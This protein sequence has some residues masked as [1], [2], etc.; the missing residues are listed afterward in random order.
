MKNSFEK[1][2]IESC[3]IE[4]DEDSKTTVYHVNSPHAFTQAAGYLKYTR[5]KTNEFIFFRGQRRLYG[6][7][8]PT[9]YRKI[10]TNRGISNSHREINTFSERLRKTHNIFASLDKYSIEA[11]LQHYGLNTTWIDLVDNI[12]V[13]LWFACHRAFSRG[14]GRFLHF[15]RR[16]P[17]VDSNPFAYILLIATQSTPMSESIPGYYKGNTTELID[18]RIST[19]SLF[20]RPHAQHGV[21]FRIRSGREQRPLDYQSQIAGVIRIDLA[22][23]LDWLGDGT[24]TQIHALFPPPYYDRGYEF[25]LATQIPDNNLLGNI[26]HIGT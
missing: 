13:A 21:L 11:T 14:D 3:S 10:K 26:H 23:A 25:L 15:E 2:T 19:P 20:L 8:T 6:S 12:W 22:N 7:L 18:L 5:G 9:I 16:S 4:F 1:L 17:Q 24:M